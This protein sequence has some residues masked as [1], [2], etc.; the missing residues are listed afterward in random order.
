MN[1]F[2]RYVVRLVASFGLV[3][4]MSTAASAS[5]V[6]D[7]ATGSE[8]QKHITVAGKLNTRKSKVESVTNKRK[9]IVERLKPGDELQSALK[10]IASAH[11]L[12]AGVILSAVGSLSSASLRFAGAN[13]GTTI[14]GPLEVVSVTGTVSDTSMHVH[15]SVSDSTGKTV[16]GHLMAGCKVFTTI[17]L[18]IIDLSD[19]W[20]FDRKTDEATTYL[21]LDP[22]PTERD[23]IGK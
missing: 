16:G 12:K 3:C 21:E 18:V 10:R 22:Q 5:A 23:A 14:E 19:E 6:S 1:C 2:Y 9:S 4:L 20:T 13:E 7:P 17:E 8:S 11:K 15:L